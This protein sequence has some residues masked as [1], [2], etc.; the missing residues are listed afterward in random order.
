MP[1]FIHPPR[2]RCPKCG[3]ELARVKRTTFDHLL[4]RVRP[5]KRMLC[6]NKECAWSAAIARTSQHK[7]AIV[8]IM[9]TAIVIAL[10]VL[11]S[12]SVSHFSP[13]QGGL[14]KTSRS[15]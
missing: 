1:L 4:S 13:A 11:V 14:P 5:V 3:A 15:R 2:T 10:S 8:P 12:V 9:L 7:S 6:V